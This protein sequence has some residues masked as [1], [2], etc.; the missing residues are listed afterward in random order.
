MWLPMPSAA[1]SAADLEEEDADIVVPSAV[2]ADSRPRPTS[3]AP[4]AAAEPAPAAAPNVSGLSWAVPPIP[5][6]GSLGLAMGRTRNEIGETLGTSTVS[7]NGSG[8]SYV[9]APWLATLLGSV[10]ASQSRQTGGQQ[11]DTANLSLST[12]A[13]SRSRYPLS[14]AVGAGTSRSSGAGGKITTTDFR[15]LDI[16]QAYTP[17][18][19]S[20]RTTW[21][22]NHAS[23]GN[24]NGPATVSNQINGSLNLKPSGEL[25]QTLTLTAGA[26]Q[27]SS[28]GNGSRSGDFGISHSIYLEDYVMSIGSDASVRLS[29]TTGADTQDY[30]FYQLGSR[31]DWIPSD[32]YPLRLRGDVRHLAV[33]SKVDGGS[34]RAVASSTMT[35]NGD[36]P[37]SKNWALSGYLNLIRVGEDSQAS[38]SS[39][40]TTSLGGAASWSGD[41]L[42]RPIDGWNYALNYGSSFSANATKSQSDTESRSV[43]VVSAGGN[44]GHSATRALGSSGEARPATLALSQSYGATVTYGAGVSQ[45]VA[46]TLNHSA[47]FRWSPMQDRPRL[48]ASVTAS[49]SRGFGTS[50]YEYQT[51]QGNAN[52]SIALSAYEN[53]SWYVNLPLTRQGG[54]NTNSRWQG[55]VTS[56]LGYD[57][58]RFARVSGLRYMANYSIMFRERLTSLPEAPAAGP[59]PQ[60][61]AIDHR[62]TQTWSWRLGLLGWSISNSIMKTDTG[63]TAASIDLTV[64]RDFGGVL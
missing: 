51:I 12:S 20:F 21:N 64:T 43:S 3:A 36:Y 7:L 41:G 40:T 54:P 17:P 25:P 59:Q 57:N 62:F 23:F 6:R 26:G 29:Q 56:G 4:L 24:S 14:A 2:Q 46:H 28:G 32:D 47:T 11:T 44:I 60:G 38:S 1:Q 45:P 35:V 61:Y 9:Y 33:S 34:E 48:D 55:T 10:G 53:V 37:L 42:S 49:D 18:S 19:E 8:S 30:L 39:T 63:G 13:L 16:T 31:M 27:T 15:R 5:Y 52:E 22:F 58:A 50:R